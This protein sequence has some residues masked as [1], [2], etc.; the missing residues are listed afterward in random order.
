[1]IRGT[2]FCRQKDEWFGLEE[3][4]EFEESAKGKVKFKGFIEYR[5]SSIL[6]IKGDSES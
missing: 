2:S 5:K 1:M 3:S 6:H 4:V